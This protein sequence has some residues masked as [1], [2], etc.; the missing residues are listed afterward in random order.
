MAIISKLRLTAWY[1]YTAVD[2]IDS[3]I[4]GVRNCANEKESLLMSSPRQELLDGARII[5]N[6][7]VLRE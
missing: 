6:G 7:G 4:L 5:A 2:Q 3:M 1:V